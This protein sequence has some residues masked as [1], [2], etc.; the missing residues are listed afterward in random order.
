MEGEQLTPAQREAAK[1]DLLRFTALNALSFE[2]LAGQILI[3]FARQVGC[4]LSDIGLLSALLPFAA[5]IQLGVAPLVNRFGPRALMLAGW[6]A[7]TVVSAA[8][9]FVPAAAGG[10]PTAGT[11]LILLIMGAFYLCR[12]LGMSSW[13]PLVQE[14]VPPQDRGMFLSRQEWLRQVSIVVI[15]VVTALYLIGAEGL[16]RFLHIIAVGVTAAA[17]SLY[18]L[19]RVPDVGL[20]AEPLDKEYFRRATAPLRDAVFRRYLAFSVSL[21]AVL[22]SFG[23]FLIVFLRE[24][25]HLQPSGVIAVSTVGSLGAIATLPLW[26]RW[27]DRVGAKPALGV[28]IAGVAGALVL[29]TLATP[30][31]QWVWLGAPAISLVLGIFTGGLTVSMSKFELG[32][33]PIRGRTHYV[34][35]NVTVVG[36]CSG[37]AAFAAGRLLERLAPARVQFAWLVLDRYRI[38]FLLMAVLFAVPFLVR[39]TL[40]EERSRSLRSLF[41]RELLRRSRR[42]RRLLRKPRPAPGE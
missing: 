2:V 24:G 34:A 22:S 1:S 39:A 18:Y 41:Q 3:L 32:F 37:I 11:R 10:S 19:W 31:A 30:E 15:A 5:I 27:S 7:R 33:I 21:R 9:F 13:L 12:A 42:M 36:L 20:A 26:G 14:L 29:W 38:F 16:T 4:S 17:L 28:S 6:G 25:L 23:P 8:L 40:P 35:M